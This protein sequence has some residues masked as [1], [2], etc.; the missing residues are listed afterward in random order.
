MIRWSDAAQAAL[1][2]ANRSPDLSAEEVAKALAAAAVAKKAS[3]VRSAKLAPLEPAPDV[4]SSQGRARAVTPFLMVAM[5]KHPS[6]VPYLL[7]EL[8]AHGLSIPHRLLPL[9]LR[10]TGA[11]SSSIRLALGVRGGWL[12]S[13]MSSRAGLSQ[14][15]SEGARASADPPKLKE[16][17]KAFPALAAAEPDVAAEWLAQHWKELSSA[18]RAVAAS[19]LWESGSDV[20]EPVFELARQDSARE[21]R[22]IVLRLLVRMGDPDALAKAEDAARR[23]L[24]A[25]GG[26]LFQPS[27][28]QPCDP[29]EWE[30]H[31]MKRLRPGKSGDQATLS[32]WNLSLLPPS[33]TEALLG[34]VETWAPYIR[35][36]SNQAQAY[37]ALQTAAR[38]HREPAVTRK[39]LSGWV[40][41]GWNLGDVEKDW[42]VFSPVER[43]ELLRDG[44]RRTEH[45]HLLERCVELGDQTPK[46]S[47]ETS[48]IYVD[49]LRHLVHLGTAKE[50]VRLMHGFVGRFHPDVLPEIARIADDLCTRYSNSVVNGF[51]EMLQLRIL[52]DAKLRT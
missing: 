20:F 13:Q 3:D 35:Q 5:I 10:H 47:K 42:S 41:Q 12:A 8:V 2:G 25:E 9:A 1:L 23:A 27:R 28:S 36:A 17:L 46:W 49:R 4:G 40:R 11:A 32:L 50:D 33:H 16:Q 43:D 34:P 44:L 15:K 29:G 19:R 14:G 26:G 6:L 51:R 24:V 37:D 39:I 30:L 52:F 18:Q 38:F 31:G 7:D 48:L 21:V 45:R 22:M